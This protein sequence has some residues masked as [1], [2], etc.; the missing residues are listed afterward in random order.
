MKTSMILFK[1]PNVDFVIAI[2]VICPLVIATPVSYFWLR[3]L[4]QANK[5]RQELHESNQRLELTL[6]EVKELSGLLP[7]CTS[8]KKI[9]DDKGYLNQI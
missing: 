7:I 1:M 9:R 8:C 4:E 5:N 3:L 2:A 6:K